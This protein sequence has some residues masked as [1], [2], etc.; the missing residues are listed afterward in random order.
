M[1]SGFRTDAGVRTCGC[2]FGIEKGSAAPGP[3][4]A[5]VFRKLQRVNSL[6][7]YH[8]DDRFSRNFG[9]TGFRR[10]LSP[11]VYGEMPRLRRDSQGS[12]MLA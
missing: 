1:M 7:A 3:V 6:E 2:A 12:D 11:D 10:G 9:A 4:T 5:M 8:P